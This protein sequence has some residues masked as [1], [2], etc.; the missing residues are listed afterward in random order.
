MNRFIRTGGGKMIKKLLVLLLSI[1]ICLSLCSC[2]LFSADTEEL[3]A[4]PQL[5]GDMLPIKAALE[6][7][8]PKGYSLKY[9]SEGEKRSAVVLED[10]NND[11]L[12][13]ALA[14]Y[15]TDE[16]ELTKMHINLIAF[17]SKE[18]ESICEASVTA[19]GIEKVEFC[20]LNG[21]GKKEIAVGWEIFG[22]GE[23]RLSVYSFENKELK[24]LLDEAYTS[25]LCCDLSGDNK[26]D[27]FIQLLSAS[28]QN[29]NA[30]L[31]GF[32]DNSVIRIGGCVMDKSVKTALQ[33]KL[34]TLSTGQNAVY[35]D[36]I[37]GIGAVTEVIFYKKGEL[38][39]GLLDNSGS[40]EN[41]VTLR[42]SSILSQDI[43][44][45]GQIE[46]PVASA[47]KNADIESKEIMYYTN[48]CT[49]N[50]EALT[51]KR[52]T[53]VNSVDG[54]TVELPDKLMGKIAVKKNNDAKSRIIY[55]F[56]PETD[57]IG[58]M[59]TEFLTVKSEK[60]DK[61]IYKEYIKITQS[62]GYTYLYKT[63]V[64]AEN[65]G[66]NEEQIKNMFKLSD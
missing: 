53:V 39:N 57:E 7:S 44:G 50:G 64:E 12:N 14:F 61:K 31:F 26:D 59:I 60:Y 10:I 19:G 40:M 17:N 30:K 27:I 8:A 6:K 36:E 34:A 46:I 22:S 38:V 42:Q 18:W 51:V 55:S 33:P 20:D 25:F 58:G 1:S 49:Y 13:E 43:N 21:D 16:D 65:Q 11:G 28:D 15:S 29:N 9:P 54:Y 35:I 56:N 48:W 47:L 45:D 3:I 32:K 4:P 62:K 24:L 37:K 2:A 5:S 63:G 41:T 52:S 66:I 23:K